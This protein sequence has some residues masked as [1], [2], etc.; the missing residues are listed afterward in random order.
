MTHNFKSLI[1]SQSLKFNP[2]HKIQSLNP[3]PNSEI[4]SNPNRFGS[5]ILLQSLNESTI[6]Y[7]LQSLTLIPKVDPAQIDWD[8]AKRRRRIRLTGW[9]RLVPGERETQNAPSPGWS[10]DGAPRVFSARPLVSAQPSTRSRCYG[11]SP[12]AIPSCSKISS[13]WL[14]LFLFSFPRFRRFCLSFQIEISPVVVMNCSASTDSIMKNVRLNRS[15]SF[16]YA[17]WYLIGRV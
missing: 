6:I 4:R 14:L 13:P 16:L 1:I 5:P 12:Y 10:V 3:N 11:D 8:R 7:K 9:D 15:R 2:T 17:W